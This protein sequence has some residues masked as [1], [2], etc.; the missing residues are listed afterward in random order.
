MLA[1]RLELTPRPLPRPLSFDSRSQGSDDG[2][3]TESLEAADALGLH[4][5][6]R[7]GRAESRLRRG[8]GRSAPSLLA[9]A[10]LCCALEANFVTVTLISY[11]LSC[12][13]SDVLCPSHTAVLGEFFSFCPGYYM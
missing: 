7:V 1:A 10:R 13:G 6:A 11:S 9:P 5:Y 12:F 2:L 4:D 3:L 8:R